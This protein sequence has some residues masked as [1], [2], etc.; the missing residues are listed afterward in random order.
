MLVPTAAG[1]AAHPAHATLLAY[2]PTHTSYTGID[3][4]KGLF[5]TYAPS[6]V[7]TDATTRYVFYCGNQETNYVKDHIFLSVGHQSNGQW[8]YTKPTI[9]FGP[10]NGPS[11]AFFSVHTCEPEVIGG[12]FHFG[13]KPYKWAMFFTAEA[14]ASNSTNVIGLAFANSPAGPWKADLTPFIETSADFG[15]NSYPNNCPV[16]KASGQTFYCLG[17]P[18]ATSIGGGHVLLTYMGNSGS[19]GTDANPAEGLVLR[20][21]NLSNVPSAGPCTTCFLTLPSGG[22]VEAV[23][24]NGLGVWPHDASIAYDPAA[25]RVAM[26]FDDGPYDTTTN[27]PPVT[28]VVT[29]ATIGLGGLLQ[30]SGTWK[31]QGTYGQ[32]LSGY[33]Y[34]HNS[35]IVRTANGDLPSSNRLEVLNAVADNNIGNKWGV[36]DYRLW[37][38][39]API[40]GGPS[41]TSVASASATCQGLTVVDAK[42][43]VTTGGAAHNAGSLP[44]S[45]SGGSITGMALTPDRHGYYLVA[46]NGRVTTY[47]DAVNRGS[48]STSGV[49][50]IAVDATSGGYWVARSNGS[51]KGFGT[52]SL[53]STT[54][55]TTSGP[56]VSIVAIPNG[57]GYYLVTA[58]GTVSAFG[59]AQDYGS[60]TVPSGQTVAAMAT[61]PNGLGYY[62]VT[63]EGTL[64]AYGDAKMF[65]APSVANDA[66]V[67][68]M[69]V[70]LDG[71][72][73]WVMSSTGVVTGYGTASSTLLAGRVAT[74]PAVAL[75]TS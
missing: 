63:K 29:E 73:Y 35:G 43:H 24:L 34:N 37:D 1:A 54:T 68:D 57:R 26:S 72:G 40:S 53:G 65:S 2:T 11:N 56:V 75:A 14:V 61:T 51:V 9:V 48:A 55:T 58:G 28:P 25:R 3:P 71:F 36:W 15:Q 38:T 32:C 41:T 50:G 23:T 74:A 17:E 45:G 22:K 47:G 62:L 60:A 6:T 66:P 39:S 13:G 49:V 27:G 5:Y 4:G 10:E 7:Q 44:S 46:A 33:T 70:A 42:G 64:A 67:A 59:N 18:A 52:G 8:H 30:G 21:I 16:D 12:Q 19:P 20:E 31:P 69:A